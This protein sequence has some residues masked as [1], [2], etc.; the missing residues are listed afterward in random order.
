MLKGVDP[1]QVAQ[2]E[3]EYLYSRFGRRFMAL[4]EVDIKPAYKISD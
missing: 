3:N 1:N 4:R 2:L